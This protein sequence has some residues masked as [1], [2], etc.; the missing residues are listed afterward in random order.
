MENLKEFDLEKFVEN[1]RKIKQV[2]ND[3]DKCL[4]T[5]IIEL[6]SSIKKLFANEQIYIYK[7]LI[8]LKLE[9][10]SVSKVG[11]VQ[12][13]L[14]Y[15]SQTYLDLY[16]KEFESVN[17]LRDFIPIPERP[18]KVSAEVI[19]EY[20]ESI[21]KIRESNTKI[22]DWN[23]KIYTLKEFLDSIIFIDIYGDKTMDVSL[24]PYLYFKFLNTDI[25][26]I[27]IFM[28]EL[29][30]CSAPPVKKI[31]AIR[32]ED[33]SDR[34]PKFLKSANEVRVFFNNNDEANEFHASKDY[35]ESV[36][37]KYIIKNDTMFADGGEWGMYNNRKNNLNESVIQDFSLDTIPTPISLNDGE[38]E[39]NEKFNDS[40]YEVD[41]SDCY[42]TQID[43]L[44]AIVPKEFYDKYGTIL[45]NKKMFI[46]G[47]SDNKK[48]KRT[49]IYFEYS[50]N[51]DDG[52][53]YLSVMS[54]YSEELNEYISSNININIKNNDENNDENTYNSAQDFVFAYGLHE[55]SDEIILA[56]T[57][58][59][60]WESENCLS[61][62]EDGAE[63]FIMKGYELSAEMESI[64][65]L[66]YKNGSAV[67]KLSEI[68]LVMY[69]SGFEYSWKLQKFLDN[70][71]SIIN[72]NNFP[73][74]DKYFIALKAKMGQ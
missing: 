44:F 3:F 65:S 23:T 48:W 43:N 25:D 7:E 22:K 73:N 71:D 14:N 60:Y 57:P 10:I 50:G 52:Y 12:T 55:Y 5:D 38:I 72:A 27:E 64:F 20:N 16:R 1:G 32:I 46:T 39:E 58:K 49:D 47:I 40:D 18:E 13:I 56:I 54:E 24:M 4:N 35:V 67:T 41:L 68:K 19:K 66:Y 59:K 6:E 17:K 8:N 26:E 2:K 31:K 28:S 33:I 29:K 30:N 45:T 11:R 70:S 9:N 34:L 21:K 61:D 69:K 37:E 74:F 36:Y 63:Q 42:Y 53:D 62:M 51:N 15:V